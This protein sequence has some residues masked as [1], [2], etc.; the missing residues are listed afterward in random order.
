MTIYA[1]NNCR[2]PFPPDGL[3][4]KCPHCGGVYALEGE[5]TFSPDAIESGQSGIWRYRHSFGL[6]EAAP[7]LTLG[8]GDTPLVKSEAFGQPVHFKLEYLNPT[9]SF[10]DRATA[11]LLSELLA[12]GVQDAVEDSSGNA[13]ASFAAYAARAGIKARVFVPAYASGPKR[14]QIRAYGAELVP[15]DGPRSM[16]AE[17]VRRAAEEGAVYA[18]HAM[19]PQGIP[20]LATIAYELFDQLGAAPGTVIAPAG[21]GSLLLGVAKGFEALKAAG[22]MSAD[23]Q[24]VGVQALACAPLWAVSTMGPAPGMAWAMEGETLAEGVRV[25]QPVRGDALLAAVEGSGGRFIAIEEER[26]LPGRDAL[27]GLGFYVEPTSAIVWPALEQVLADTPP[28]HV[29][30]LTGSGL[31]WLAQDGAN[32]D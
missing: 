10:K 24:Y 1:C 29:I 27:L 18:S 23:P 13:G 32:G 11:P 7:V 16:A 20:G 25:Y 5:L 12:R 22:I 21:H 8:E 9:G 4:Y 2:R 26:I 17:A 3:P 14:A 31:K 6:S 19:L 15:I 30:I 28:P